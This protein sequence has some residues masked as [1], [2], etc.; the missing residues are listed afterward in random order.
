M[1]AIMKNVYLY[2]SY[3]LALL[4]HPRDG[5]PLRNHFFV[6][7]VSFESLSAAPVVVF[8]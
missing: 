2:F 5:V 8:L 7:E 3:S 4:F 6:I 1:C